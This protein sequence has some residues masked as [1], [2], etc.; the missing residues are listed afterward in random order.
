MEGAVKMS[1]SAVTT[2]ISN[3]TTLAGSVLDFVAGNEVLMLCFGA[4][5]VGTVIGVIHAVKNA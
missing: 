1:V 5:L 2:A 3:L 4:G